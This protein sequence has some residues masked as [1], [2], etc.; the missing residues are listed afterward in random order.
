MSNEQFEVT[1]DDVKA[2]KIMHKIII[3]EANN[4]KTKGKSDNDMVKN[5]QKMIEE[6]VKCF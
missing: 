4:L 2:K 1:I 6:E 3:E 5:I